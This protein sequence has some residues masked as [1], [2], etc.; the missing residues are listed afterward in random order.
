MNK[1]R[2]IAV[3]GP[4]QLI[5]VI[6]VLS[7]R[8]DHEGQ[9]GFNDHLVLGGMSGGTGEHESLCEVCRQ[10]AKVWPF[11]GISVFDEYANPPRNGSEFDE[12]VD[13][14]RTTVGIAD[15]SEIYVSRNWQLFNELALNAFPDSSR[16]CYG[17]GFGTIDLDG[18]Y[19]GYGACCPRGFLSIDTAYLFCPVAEDAE[20]KGLLKLKRFV[21]PPH[22]HLVDTIRSVAK[23]IP[24]FVSRCEALC[25]SPSDRC[26]LILTSTFTEASYFKSGYLSNFI[27]RNYRRLR[28][29]L[30]AQPI[31]SLCGMNCRREI[32]LYMEQL[33]GHSLD[34]MRV[35]VKGHPRQRLRQSTLLVGSLRKSGIAAKEIDSLQLYPIELIA[36]SI[37]F[38]IVVAFGSS[39]ASTLSLLRPECLI[40]PLVR[41]DLRQKYFR[42]QLHDQAGSRFSYFLT[43]MAKNNVR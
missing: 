4:T 39:S 41:D 29:R 27:I 15:C 23:S 9:I 37:P 21:Q 6:A 25:G 14:F 38:S 16:I 17:D 5:N 12:A 34:G 8:R 33:S 3:Q 2:I 1:N 35:F 36:C 10:I 22:A 13:L 40:D 32:A 28:R 7:Y 42:P 19:R 30:T 43:V 11:A 20:Q 31:T 26:A 24:D 18:G